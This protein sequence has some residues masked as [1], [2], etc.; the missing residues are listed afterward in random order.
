M[1]VKMAIPL[2]LSELNY[3]SFKTFKYKQKVEERKK[4]N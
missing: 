2:S 4:K 1:Q 3:R